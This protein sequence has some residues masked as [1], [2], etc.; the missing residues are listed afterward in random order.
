MLNYLNSGSKCTSII[1]LY[2]QSGSA[3]SRSEY[4][5]QAAML[6]FTFHLWLLIHSVVGQSQPSYQHVMTDLLENGNGC[7]LT[8]LFEKCQ[9]SQCE[10]LKSLSV[11]LMW[12]C[13]Q[14]W[15]CL[16]MGS[17]LFLARRH[18]HAV[19]FSFIKANILRWSHLH[20]PPFSL[21]SEMCKSA[22]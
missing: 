8:W 5:F 20:L 6:H 14:C 18:G 2:S 11:C 7:I 12:A 1:S 15:L 3:F 10:A 19:L 21:C 9:P 4:H 17:S 13:A 22:S 16:N